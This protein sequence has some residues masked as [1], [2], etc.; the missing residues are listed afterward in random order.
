MDLCKNPVKKRAALLVGHM[1]KADEMAGLRTLEHMVDTVL[2]WKATRPK[3]CVSCAAQKTLRRH[4]R[5][6]AV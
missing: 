5:N 4:R 6:R 1:T 3:G 2:L